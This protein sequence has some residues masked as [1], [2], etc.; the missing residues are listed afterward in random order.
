VRK[1]TN[2]FKNIYIFCTHIIELL[3]VIVLDGL[4]DLLNVRKQHNIHIGVLEDA[5]VK[6]EDGMS[7]GQVQ[8]L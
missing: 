4:D 8:A 5:H 6:G 2:A 1:K 7:N 3:E